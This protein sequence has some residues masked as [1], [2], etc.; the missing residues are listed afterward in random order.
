MDTFFTVPFHLQDLK[1]NSLNWWPYK[2]LLPTPE[3]LVFYQDTS[4]ELIILLIPNNY[5]LDI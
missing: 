2:Q 3:N 5:L 1:A 4:P